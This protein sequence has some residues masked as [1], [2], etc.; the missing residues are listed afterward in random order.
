MPT[1]NFFIKLSKQWLPYKWYFLGLT[2]IGLILI[3][4]A[5]LINI[6]F[7]I[8]F[9]PVSYVG[10]AILIW[11]WGIFLTIYW[12]TKEYKFAL[13]LPKN[14][15][16]VFSWYAAIFLD[17]WFLFGTFAVLIFIY[18]LFY[19]QKKGKSIRSFLLLTCTFNFKKEIANNWGHM[20]SSGVGPW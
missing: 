9:A 19:K 1:P 16:Y 12:Y 13:K 7:E 3:L 8:N 17:A 10:F 20:Q 2:G 4:I 11:G 18:S 5:P 6:K 14:L 15:R